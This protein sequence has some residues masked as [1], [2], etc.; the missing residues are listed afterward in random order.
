MT[1]FLTVIIS[2]G[3]VLCFVYL[4]AEASKK[5]PPKIEEFSLSYS[6]EKAYAYILFKYYQKYRF[7]PNHSLMIDQMA[8]EIIYHDA[9]FLCEFKCLRYLSYKDI[10]QV[11]KNLRTIYFDIA[12]VTTWQ[13]SYDENGI[14]LSEGGSVT[15]YVLNDT[16]ISLIKEYYGEGAQQ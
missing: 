11:R 2:A 6:E 15:Y 10:K 14:L 7:E 8:Y 5:Y 9:S 4:L 12:F 1:T 3:V 16:A 13:P